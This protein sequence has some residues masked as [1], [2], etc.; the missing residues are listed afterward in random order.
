MFAS[1]DCTCLCVIA[2]DSSIATL[3]VSD[4]SSLLG[5][6]E[7]VSDTPNSDTVSLDI[8]HL[9]QEVA[10]KGPVQS[11]VQLRSAFILY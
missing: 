8:E 2:E 11:E 1:L 5:E 6:F 7:M 3:E 10:N 4:S 9:S